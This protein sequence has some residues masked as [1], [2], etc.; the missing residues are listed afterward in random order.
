MTGHPVIEQAAVALLCGWDPL[1]YLSFSGQER[2][3]A[4]LILKRA[5]HLRT[6]ELQRLVEA[7]GAH[8]GN[9]V[10]EILARA[11]AK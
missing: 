3:I 9:R 5:A 4:D 7:V 2:L 1:R 10:G 11:F 6:E 8:T